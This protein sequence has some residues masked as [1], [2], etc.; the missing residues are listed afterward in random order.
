MAKAI[1]LTEEMQEKVNRFLTTWHEAERVQFERRYQNLNYDTY[2]PKTAKD[3]RKYVALDRGT[4][5]VFLL[6]KKTGV[7]FS[8]KAYGVPNRKAANSIEELTEQHSQVADYLR[9]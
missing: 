7:V 2:A 4:S 3:R 6:C 5:G 8:I 9:S 1:T